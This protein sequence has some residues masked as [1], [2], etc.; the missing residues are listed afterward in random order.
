MV[1]SENVNG[2]DDVMGNRPSTVN[3]LH[4]ALRRNNQKLVR[5]IIN[6]SDLDLN[7]KV[8][9][10][11][12]FRPSAAVSRDGLLQSC[13][14]SRR[15]GPPPPQ[16]EPLMATW[17][18]RGLYTESVRSRWKGEAVVQTL[19]FKWL[20]FFWKWILKTNAP[21]NCQLV[22]WWLSGRNGDFA[23]KVNTENMCVGSNTA[24]GKSAHKHIAEWKPRHKRR[25]DVC[26]PV[27]ATN[28]TSFISFFCRWTDKQRCLSQFWRR[29]PRS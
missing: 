18:G 19:P 9:N 29:E 17:S 21:A 27:K 26:W 28:F 11:Q 3:H 4:E 12:N 23:K 22:L 6:T 24:R 7:T 25:P 8:T 13:T 10:G 14:C 2:K 15:R 1:Y 16:G 20:F 5:H